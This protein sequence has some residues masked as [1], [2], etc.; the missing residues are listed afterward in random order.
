[1]LSKCLVTFLCC[2]F[3]FYA[4]PVAIE[5][6]VIT[7]SQLCAF[8]K[9][10][11]VTGYKFS[12]FRFSF[13]G[14]TSNEH[15]ISRHFTIYLTQPSRTLS[16][17]QSLLTTCNGQV[18]VILIYGKRSVIGVLLLFL[19]LFVSSNVDKGKIEKLPRDF[20]SA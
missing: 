13:R 9:D 8:L 7:F 12:A 16:L 5:A 2:G 4:F 18:T 20:R 6:F 15:S 11:L 3:G 1:M 14:Q 19:V 17:Q 10:R